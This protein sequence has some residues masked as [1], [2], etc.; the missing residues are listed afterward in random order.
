MS[1]MRS[2]MRASSSCNALMPRRRSSASSMTAGARRAAASI[3]ST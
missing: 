1:G 3:T 2:A